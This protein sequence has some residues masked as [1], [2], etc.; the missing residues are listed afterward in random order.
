MHPIKINSVDITFHY[1]RILNDFSI[2]KLTTSE[3][4]IKF[5]SLILDE[6]LT[7]LKTQSVVFEKGSCFYC[8]YNDETLNTN[9]ISQN[10]KEVNEGENFSI[11]KIDSLDA[12]KCMPLHLLAQL[13]L[14]SLAAP[15]NSLLAFNNLAGYLFSLNSQLFVKR[16][17]NNEEL[18]IK[19]PSIKIRIDKRLQMQ[20]E[21]KT[22]SSLLLIKKLSLNKHIN[23]YSKYTISHSSQ[24]LRRILPTEKL[25]ASQVFIEKQEVGKKTII[26]FFSFENQESFLKSKMGFLYSFLNEVNTKLPEYLSLSFKEILPEK[27]IKYQK[28]LQI[29][30]NTIVN[31]IVLNNNFHIVDKIND[32]DSVEFCNDLKESFTTEYPETKISK[33]IKEKANSFNLIVIHNSDYYSKYNLEDPYK[34]NVQTNTSQHITIEDFKYS[35]KSVVKNTVKELCIKLD[36]QKGYITLIDWKKFNYSSHWKF[37][38]KHEN[39]FYFLDISPKGQMTFSQFENT[40]FTQTEYSEYCDIYDNVMSNNK[41]ESIEGIVISDKNDINIIKSTGEYTIPDFISVGQ[42]FDLVN[43][44][45]KIEKSKLVTIFEDFSTRFSHSKN[46][47]YKSL[48]ENFPEKIFE[49]KSILAIIKHRTVRKEFTEYFYK[50]TGK[51][52][53][54]YFKDSLTRYKLMDSNLDIK[55]FTEDNQGLY[56]VGT[57]GEGIQS[58]F[59]RASKIRKIVPYN[60][61][62]LLFD[63]LLPTMNVDFVKHENITVLPFPFKYLREYVHQSLKAKHICNSH[64][65]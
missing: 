41:N 32:E 64:K 55:Y 15:K 14:N 16:K 52:L 10:L 9:S 65:P 18:I 36:I 5:G 60:S 35:T 6:A 39:L 12:I 48:I 49:R 20:L 51:L 13:F 40:L 2:F 3:K 17:S 57:K 59:P 22:F 27:S 28:R 4:F 7:G 42:T 56:F 44:P 33:G 53:H 58:S 43:Q 34:N 37:G 47:D 61:S 11:E 25:S 29:D 62:K 21:V 38:V 46:E 1:N 31:A 19:I 54:Y 45:F 50:C 23:D 63:K 30:K 24:K 26:P 8:L